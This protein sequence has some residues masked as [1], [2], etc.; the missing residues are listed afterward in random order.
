[1]NDESFLAPVFERLDT[2]NQIH[3]GQVAT[4]G[5]YLPKLKEPSFGDVLELVELLRPFAFSGTLNLVGVVI[6]KPGPSRGHPLMF[7]PIR[8]TTDARIWADRNDC[9]EVE[10]EHEP[11]SLLFAKGIITYLAST[12]QLI[13]ERPQNIFVNDSR[14]KPV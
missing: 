6:P 5:S 3:V 11:S 8:S 12:I 9:F 2:R 14:G 4:N 13:Q 1:M 7:Q 10:N